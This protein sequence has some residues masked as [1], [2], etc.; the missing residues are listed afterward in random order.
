MKY[1]DNIS[2][3]DKKWIKTHFGQADDIKYLTGIL[4]DGTVVDYKIAI[5]CS[6]VS[7]KKEVHKDIKRVRKIKTT[8][9]C[10]NYLSVH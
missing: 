6:P 10:L 3:E 4:D 9:K 2:E 5:Y 7:I 1:L 8:K